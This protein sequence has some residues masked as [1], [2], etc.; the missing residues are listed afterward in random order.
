MGSALVGA[1]FSQ[2]GLILLP[3]APLHVL[4][5]VKH[6][7]NRQPSRAAAMRL[8]RLPQVLL[9]IPLTLVASQRALAQSVPKMELFG[10]YSNLW[11]HKRTVHGWNASIAFNANRWLA[12][13][14]DFSGHYPADETE[15]TRLSTTTF[16]V[17]QHRF[18]LGPRFSI[19]KVE[20]VT[21]YFH[22]LSGVA[23]TGTA[24]SGTRSFD[25]PPTGPFPFSDLRSTN[26][27][28][29]AVGAGLEIKASDR[30]TLRLIQSDYLRDAR[31]ATG[32]CRLICSQGIR[33]SS[34][35]VVGFGKI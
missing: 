32:F 17:D 6:N 1:G 29:G 28:S 8:R 35:I 23:H 7:I 33:F 12:L 34:G 10:G 24:S 31:Q 25:I 9:A 4:R 15:V 22:V 18:Y 27:F 5:I 2:V 3:V 13:V 11:E 16:N 26:N 20:S 14:G 30:I 19:R 21:P